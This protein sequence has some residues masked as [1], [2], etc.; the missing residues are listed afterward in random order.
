M[1]VL[2]LHLVVHFR[3]AICWFAL[4]SKGMIIIC[5]HINMFNWI[6]TSTTVSKTAGV[7]RMSIM[8][9]CIS[10]TLTS[11]DVSFRFPHRRFF[12]FH[13]GIM[14]PSIPDYWQPRQDNSH[15]YLQNHL[16]SMH[17]S[18]IE[19]TSWPSAFTPIIECRCIDPPFSF[20]SPP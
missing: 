13:V 5:F 3:M 7:T 14:W 16:K 20:L 4:W 11:E 8:P 6:I 2:N 17:C 10:T 1:I 9:L 12:H 19:R 15:Y 18:Q